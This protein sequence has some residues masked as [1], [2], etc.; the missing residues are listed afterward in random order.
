[1]F[2][3][4][5]YITPIILSQV[6]RYVKN[7]RAEDSQVS[8][9]GGDAV[10]NNLDLRLDV[11]EE[12][13]R[14][15]FSLVSGH[16]HELQIHVPWTRLHTE[17]IVL[18]INTI[19]CVLKLPSDRATSV[20]SSASSQDGNKA[21]ERKRSKR[22][23]EE[24]S[25]PPGYIQGL[26]NKI[27]SNIQIVC[28]NLIL[29][30]VEDDL[31]LSLNVRTASFASCNEAWV[32]AF[33]ELTLP[34][35]I[36][37]KLVSVS[38]LTICL[39]R[40]GAT[41]KIEVYQDPLLY[42]CSLSVRVGWCY[43]SLTA[44]V[45]FRTVINVLADRMDFS[46]TGVQV[47]MVVRLSRL[48]LAFY[49]G[50]LGT[51]DVQERRKSKN[52]EDKR[53]EVNDS[54]LDEEEGSLGGLLWD[55]GT[56]LGTALL[57]VYWEDEDNPPP[58]N[59]PP[60][61]ISSQ[62]GC[63]I[64][65]SS[66]TLKLAAN[67]KQKGFYRGGKQSFNSYLI[68]KVQGIYAEVSTKGSN[69]IAVQAGVSQV[70]VSPVGQPSETLPN[71]ILSGCESN[72]FL[73]RSLFAPEYGEEESTKPKE[74]RHIE[75]EHW[76]VHIE[77]V[78]ETSLL[79]KTPALAMDYVY[80]LD[81]PSDIGSEDLSELGHDLENSNLPERALC[82]F[83]IGPAQVHL[84]ESAISRANTVLD[85]VNNY[86]YLPYIQEKPEPGPEGLTLPTKEEIDNLENNNPVRVYR[87]TLLHPSLTLHSK[88]GRIEAG[89][90]CA[91]IVQQVPMYP[92]RNV[93]AGSVMHPPSKTI[94]NNCHSNITV[95]L[96]DTWVKLNIEKFSYRLVSL[97]KA[98]FSYRCLLFKQFWKNLYQKHGDMSLK[99]D[100]IQLSSSMPQLTMAM[101][102][103]ENVLRCKKV[104]GS[105]L[106]SDCNGKEH[107]IV[108]SLFTGTNFAWTWTS[109]IYTLALG[110]DGASVSLKGH[111]RVKPV[112]ILTGISQISSKNSKLANVGHS[113]GKA[114]PETVKPGW[115]KFTVQWPSGTLTHNVPTLLYAALGETFILA[116]PKLGDVLKY[117]ASTVSFTENEKYT[118]S[119]VCNSAL[120]SGKHIK[121][122]TSETAS[123]VTLLQCLSGTI[124]DVKCGG[125]SLYLSDKTLSNVSGQTVLDVVNKAGKTKNGSNLV[126]LS[127][128]SADIH[129]ANGK[130]D[131]SQYSQHPVLFAPAVW[132]SGKENFPWSISLK[133]FSV[134]RRMDSQFSQFLQ[135]VTTNCTFGTS[136]KGK[137]RN[138]AI[139]IHA[140]MTAL[141]FF[142]D[143]P[144]LTSLVMVSQCLV[145]TVMDSF[146]PSK[147]STDSQIKVEPVASTS[148]PAI[149]QRSLGSVSE[150]AT[151]V[152]S[153]IHSESLISEDLANKECSLWLQWTI[154]QW[155]WTMVGGHQGSQTKLTFLFEDSSAS[156]DKQASYTKLKF[157][158]RSVTG[159]HFV[160][161]DVEEFVPGNF[162]GRTI[163]CQPDL[164]KTIY[165]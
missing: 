82:R 87:L 101:S 138:L 36:L 133:G 9:W 13:L 119:S 128:L 72:K 108:S 16:I 37:R 135:P 33:T 75:E 100:S 113:P 68:C 29:K 150:S 154:P 49:Y 50:E 4:E 163:S 28:N 107:P 121:L 1:M 103:V 20:V 15:P 76:D 41:G 19:E 61:K 144:T 97:D 159:N 85:L 35:L 11:L 27:I 31:V 145:S 94:L 137:A 116:D 51:K 73:E 95:T 84:S 132:T 86:D 58:Q 64:R 106:T 140:D 3:L 74:L 151:P 96:M 17:P 91:D 125:V 160:E 8:L 77:T 93:R 88:G 22:T 2:K 40:R 124:I 30:Y 12:E 7:I 79:E 18:T 56:S 60:I 32:P 89:L 152:T 104:D 157:R 46:M 6:E 10:F 21:E 65:E 149:I 14:L 115:L 78:T 70:V 105:D 59:L 117:A 118:E 127:L 143:T 42:R 23:K 134:G 112:P 26:I 109:E 155:T 123:E 131:L 136:S 114:L 25:A 158:I 148:G 67:V 48:F 146:P 92:L 122:N 69:W 44:K 139:C 161:K 162:P 120:K 71:Y 53:T 110:I 165:A 99:F 55:V 81:I 129:N 62:L 130:V 52:P 126:N 45:P 54:L 80:N 142:V 111:G 38:D 98:T 164:L 47:P 90:R 83:V 24:Q 147:E 141:E 102:I 153:G 5:S 43:Q 57:P 156:I 34:D 63:Y 66:L 39:D